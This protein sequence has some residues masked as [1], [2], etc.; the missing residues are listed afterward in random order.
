LGH[1][2]AGT[3]CS[4][5]VLKLERYEEGIFEAGDVLRLGSLCSW[6]VLKLRRFEAGTFMSWELLYWGSFS[7]G[8]FCLGTLCP[9]YIIL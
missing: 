7:A 4:Y 9:I 2:I 6:D 3:F 5:D 1:F 8:M